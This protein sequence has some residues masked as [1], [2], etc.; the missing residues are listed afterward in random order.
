MKKAYLDTNV[1]ID[2]LLNRFDKPRII[3]LMSS[4]YIFVVS[5][6]V[7]DEL[8]FNKQEISLFLNILK[9]INK[10]ILY[11]ITEN[12]IHLARSFMRY[13]HY[14]DALHA[15]ICYNMNIPIITRNIKDFKGIPIRVIHSTEI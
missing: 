2:I 14:N 8:R 4:E 11:T 10:I 7:L 1:I 3:D 6:V 5:N 12:D 9:N 13:T 15:A